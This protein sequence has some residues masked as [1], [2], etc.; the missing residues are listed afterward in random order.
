MKID[1]L[2]LVNYKAFQGEYVISDLTNDLNN[3]QNIILF[4]GLNGAGKT[5]IF[6]AILLCL[7]GKKNETL[8]PSRGAR[9]ENY[10]SYVTSIINN[11]AKYIS[12]TPEMRISVLLKNTGAE[13]SL[14]E[15]VSVSRTWK[16][17]DNKLEDQFSLYDSNGEPLKTIPEDSWQE[18]IEEII[19]YEVHQFFFFDGE[20]IQDFIKDEDKKLKNSLST[21]LGINLYSKLKEDLSKVKKDIISKESKGKQIGIELDE[22]RADLSKLEKEI[23]DKK[24]EIDDQTERIHEI[25]RE[26]NEINRENA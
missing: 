12:P 20:K 14:S 16:I 5:S 26:I 15:S 23:H 21:V 22:K 1:K 6:E 7:Y 17:I 24:G 3:D 11:Q 19:P 9:H 13:D 2:S 8:W 18:Y 25:D 10:Q 4:G